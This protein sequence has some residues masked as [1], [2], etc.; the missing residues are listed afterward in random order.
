LG[1]S[2]AFARLAVSSKGLAT[3]REST[4]KIS[5]VSAADGRL[6]TEPHLKKRVDL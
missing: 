5:T 6:K 2:N 1:D 4:E 3:R